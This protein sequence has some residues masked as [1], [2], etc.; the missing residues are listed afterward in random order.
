MPAQRPNS[1]CVLINAISCGTILTIPK[2][3]HVPLTLTDSRHIP[4]TMPIP[5]SSSGELHWDIYE[6][7]PCPALNALNFNISLGT[8]AIGNAPHPFRLSPSHFGQC[9]KSIRD[10]TT[11]LKPSPQRHRRYPIGPC[12]LLNV[13]PDNSKVF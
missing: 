11:S 6:A 13:S 5:P 2:L 9:S 3:T 8:L 7:V 4:Y 10:S 1:I 12:F